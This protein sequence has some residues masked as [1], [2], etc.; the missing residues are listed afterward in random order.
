MVSA[1]ML[2][3]AA[4]LRRGAPTLPP[5]PLLKA[6]RH[7]HVDDMASP[8]GILLV[9]RVVVVLRGAA[10]KGRLAGVPGKFFTWRNEVNRYGRSV[11]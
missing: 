2:P 10:M 1:F 5:V 3:L 11:E 9:D 7:D 6:S 8:E 4:H